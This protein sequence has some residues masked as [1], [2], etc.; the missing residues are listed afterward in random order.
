MNLK[1]TQILA[2]SLLLAA[3]ASPAI[4]QTPDES[5]APQ[6]DTAQPAQESPE[7]PK[8]PLVQAYQD[9]LWTRAIDLAKERLQTEPENIVVLNILGV[10]LAQSKKFDEAET[11]FEKLLTLT[12]DDGQLYSNLCFVRINLKHQQKMDTCLEATRRLPDNDELHYMVGGELENAQ[13]LDEA[14]AQYEAAYKLNPKSA[15]YLTAIT[16]IDFDRG[17][18]QKAFE[19]TDQAIKNGNGSAILYINDTIAASRIGNYDRALELVNE[20]YEKYKDPLLLIEK[21]NILNKLRKFD[22]AE[23]LW[24]QLEKDIP[25]NGLGRPRIEFGYSQLLLAKSCTTE[26]YRTCSTDAPDECC[27]R[28]QLA[29]T[30]AE[31]ASAQPSL[32]KEANELAVNLGLAQVLNNQFEKAEATLTN[33]SLT[34]IPPDNP[35]AIAALAVTLYQFSDSSDRAMG[36]QHYLKAVEGSPDYNDIDRIRQTRIWPPRLL[37]TL[38]SVQDDIKAIETKKNRKSACSCDIAVQPDHSAPIAAILGFM[39]TLFSLLILRRKSA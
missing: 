36:R 18:Y 12:P 33:A 17:D 10:S 7:A 8:D 39:M 27:K 30:F 25:K 6:K 24:I 5:Q 22:E 4:A 14:R 29:L 26:S 3:A 16:S 19:L 1:F 31:A 2:L 21:G 15:K 28:E 38:Q 20:G 13:R 23:P 32:R 34:H 9:G 35:D 37:D 11:V